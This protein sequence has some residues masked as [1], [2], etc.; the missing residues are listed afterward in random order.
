V[1]ERKNISLA[2]FDKLSDDFQKKMGNL[3]RAKEKCVQYHNRC[4]KFWRL[5]KDEK[6]RILLK[7]MD[8]KEILLGHAAKYPKI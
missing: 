8:D 5:K 2:E 6:E 3:M 1:K 7:Q 4:L